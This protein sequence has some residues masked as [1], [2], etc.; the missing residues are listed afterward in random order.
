MRVSR[1]E[2]RGRLFSFMLL[3]ALVGSGTLVVRSTHSLA[4]GATLTAQGHIWGWG[5]N[6]YGQLGKYI[7]ASCP[8]DVFG[9]ACSP[10]PGLFN[11]LGDV[12][13]VS[14]GFNYG[15]ALRADGT[16]WTWGAG[17]YGQL[18]DGTVI[19]ST[20]PV[21]VSNLSG[22]IAI[23]A[24]S[25]SN[26]ALKSDGTVWAW[27]DNDYNELGVTTTESCPITTTSYPCST[28]PVQV[29]SLSGITA[30]A[31][32][33]Q[34]SLALKSDGTVWAWGDD[35]C[36]QL[37]TDVTVPISNSCPNLAVSA[38]VPLSSVTPALVSGL[39]G[40]TITAIA[41]ARFSSAA[42]ASDGRVWTWGD[43]SAGELGTGQTS[44]ISPVPAPVNGVSGVTALAAG[45]YHY[46]ALKNDGTVWAWGDDTYQQLGSAANVMCANGPCSPIPLQVSALT[47]TVSIASGAFHSMALGSG[48][49]VWA[50]GNN[51]YGQL[52]IG[53][54]SAPIQ[55][56]VQARVTQNVAA[57][58]ASS[59]DSFALPPG[60]ADASATPTPSPPATSTSTAT[61]TPSSTDTAIP[62]PTDTAIPVPTDTATATPVAALAL[63]RAS[64]VPFQSI[65][66][67]GTNF[68]P[69]APVD[70]FWDSANS[71]P[72][73]ATTS[74]TS[75]SFS[76]TIT[77]PQAISGWHAVIA[78]GQP[79]GPIASAAVRM[80]PWLILSPRAGAMGSKVAA[81]GFGFGAQESVTLYWDKP[82][83]FLGSV[84][85]TAQGS[86]YGP[87]AVTFTV[88]LGVT[89]GFH[90]VYGIGQTSHAIGAGIF[91]VASTHA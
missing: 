64:A 42:L 10:T 78:R 70:I 91:D 24:R 12:V 1:A 37:G 33:R 21:E 6:A 53:T 61:A 62:V 85:S 2:L 77:A 43:N 75:G 17:D 55:K 27:G 49:I 41:A 7:T 79:S 28:V 13:A 5:S 48:G 47:G 20:T 30:I 22:V 44:G 51:T 66:V 86:F 18:G 83:R 54:Y 57:I 87:T 74:N 38:T 23:A 14:G 63:S 34:H 46:L 50:W 4:S 45:W 73:A 31:V 68:A 60:P 3:L 39:A 82:L 52:G 88:P 15:M 8:L 58:G 11:D 59:F 76:V 72:I 25:H 90:V 40:V 36:G 69:S 9:P 67:T 84:R 65:T 26:L 81:I 19:S 32:G 71:R 56:P 89:P 80:T 35:T 16:V 29:P